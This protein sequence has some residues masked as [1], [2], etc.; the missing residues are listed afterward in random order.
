MVVLSPLI[1][2]LFSSYSLILSFLIFESNPVIFWFFI[3]L[4]SIF[5]MGLC[6]CSFVSGFSN[7]I[8]YFL[9][10]SVSSLALLVGLSFSSVFICTFSFL[11]KFGIFPFMFWYISSI[12]SF[13]HFCFFVVL[14]FQKIPLL[15]FYSFFISVFDSYLILLV[16]VVGRLIGGFCILNC[17]DLRMLLIFSSFSSSSWLLFSSFNLVLTFLFFAFYSFSF[18]LILQETYGL[19]KV[20]VNPVYLFTLFV[21]ISGLPPFPVFIFK[22]SI[23]YF[24]FSFCADSF[25]LFILLL[26]SVLTVLG[27]FAFSFKFIVFCYSN[28]L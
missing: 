2:V 20:F 4:A 9:V 26:V 1:F 12:Y 10:Q 17:V 3:E 22:F 23:I 27:Y 16:S 15:L 18:F 28:K 24:A 13:N 25:L 6:F 7:L 19:S 21:S 11:V 14:T 5:F 8:V